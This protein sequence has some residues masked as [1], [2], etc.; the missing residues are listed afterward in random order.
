MIAMAMACE[1]S[2]LIAD[3][4]T[5]ALDVSIQAQILRL[6]RDLQQEKNTATMFITH[7]LAV[8]ANFTQRV[9]VMYA[10][11]IVEIT[12][13][14]EIFK[15]PLHPYT[16]G[17]LSSIPVLG[18][19]KDDVE[20]NRR[21]LHTIPGSLPDPKRPMIGCRFAGRCSHVM[22]KCREAEP[23]LVVIDSGHH[24]RCFLHSDE[25]RKTPSHLE[26]VTEPKNKLKK[27]GGR[28]E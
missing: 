4:P 24:V 9:M 14:R 1:P 10:G 21:L 16:Q 3:E 20:G 25:I 18:A 12:S 26:I 5:T 27:K 13:V 8:I 15:H 7:D 23:E 17:L 19:S 22:K 28:S 11:V 6:M 2:L